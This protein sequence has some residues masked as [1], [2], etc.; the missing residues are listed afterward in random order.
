VQHVLIH[1]I[2]HHDVYLGS[3]GR[4]ELLRP[5]GSMLRTLGEALIA[6]GAAEGVELLDDLRWMRLPTPIPAR[7]VDRA[8]EDRPLDLAFTPLLPAVLTRVVSRIQPED[9]LQVRLITSGELHV[10]STPVGLG[11]LLA[12]VAAAWLRAKGHRGRVE[13]EDVH[14]PKDAFSLDPG[15]LHQHLHLPL[16][17]RA[18]ALAERVGASWS[19]ELKV[20]LS[21]STGTAAMVSGLV[22]CLAPWRPELVTVHNPREHPR[23]G[24]AG[25]WTAYQARA[26]ALHE[27]GGCVPVAEDQLAPPSLEAL[28]ALRVWREAYTAAR[29]LRAEAA[30]LSEDERFWFRKGK[31]EVLAALVVR[32]A[33][34]GYVVHRGVNLEVSLPTGS[35][36]AERNAIGSAL[37]ANPRLQR[38]DLL[39][40]AVLGLDPRARRLG[41]CGACQEWL[42]KVAEVN[43]ELEVLV[44]EDATMAQVYHRPLGIGG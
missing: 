10:G 41:P 19:D 1:N 17:R 23:R 9:D 42:R 26:S 22:A 5:S 4:D 30:E 37:V 33:D 25:R 6:V 31:Q 36:C 8:A 15:T 29:P 2:G 38:R 35:L 12:G 24:D 16:Q 39:A 14:L 32:G 40:V 21:S 18:G 34:G 20:W 44:F 13:V 43:P 7:L 3:S 11:R 28:Q 27:V